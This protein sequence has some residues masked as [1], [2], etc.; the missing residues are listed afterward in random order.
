MYNKFE[1][2]A[3]GIVFVDGAASI[4]LS[5]DQRPLS[6]LGRLLRIGIGFGLVIDGSIK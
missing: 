4:L 3:G 2:V 6:N 1:Q 5:T